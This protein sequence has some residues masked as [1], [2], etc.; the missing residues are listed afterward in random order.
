M[1]FCRPRSSRG[2]TSGR[3]R[4][5]MRNISAVQRPMPRTSTSSAMISSS[6]IAGQRWTWIEPSAKCCARSAMYSVLRSE[7]PQARSSCLGFLRIDSG[8]TSP[9]QATTRSHTLCAAL[10]DICCPTM[11]RASV[12][13]GSPRRT[14]KIFGCARMMAA[15]TGSRRASERFAESQYSGFIQRQVEQQVLRLHAH[16]AVLGGQREI[17]VAAGDVAAHGGRIL[18]PQREES[19]EIAHAAGVDLVAGPELVQDRGGLGVEAHVPRPARLLDIPDR[20]YFHFEPEKM[21]HP[22]LYHAGESVQRRSPVGEAHH[23]VVLRLALPV[24]RGVGTIEHV[25]VGGSE[26]AL[27]L[28]DE[29]PDRSVAVARSVHLHGFEIREQHVAILERR[30]LLPEEELGCAQPQRV[31][32]AIEH[33]PQDD[34]RELVDEHRRHVDRALEKRHVGAFERARRKQAIAKTEH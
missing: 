15:M 3:S 28:D 14:R 27:R 4:L 30:L 9:A 8:F 17:D 22:E 32:A 20:L 6:A 1:P 12:M 26:L 29:A 11:A 2:N 13:N 25:E 5:K 33:V 34:V 23:R 31:V 18:E 16:R 10:T 21:R 7:R 24:E 19:E